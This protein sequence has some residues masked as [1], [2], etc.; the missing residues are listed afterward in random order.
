MFLR[1]IT[2]HLKTLDLSDNEIGDTGARAIADGVRDCAVSFMRQL[3][4]RHWHFNV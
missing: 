4:I 3:V 2:Q 1:Y